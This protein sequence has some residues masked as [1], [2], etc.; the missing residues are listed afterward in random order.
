MGAIVDDRDS[1]AAPKQ[2]CGGCGGPATVRVRVSP[3]QLYKRAEEALLA[4]AVEAGGDAVIGARFEHRVSIETL[5]VVS[6][7]LGGNNNQASNFI[8]LFASGTAVKT[9]A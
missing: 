9:T 3:N 1:A 7:F 6:G 4:A 8:E 5:Q 2:G